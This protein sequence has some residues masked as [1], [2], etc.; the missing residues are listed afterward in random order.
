MQLIYFGLVLSLSSLE[1]CFV[2]CKPAFTKTPSSNGKV[3][4]DKGTNSFA[5]SWDFNTDGE[6][7]TWVDL[8]YKKSGS[9]D[10]LIA[11]KIGKQLQVPRTTNYF[12]RVTTTT[13]KATFVIWYIAESDER[14][15]ECKVYFSSVS[16]PWIMSAVKLIVVVKPKITLYTT[17]ALLMTEGDTRTLLCVASGNP[18]PSYT[19]YKNNVRVQEGSDN[20]NYT[21]T[22][23]N[24]YQTGM[25]RCEA[26]VT[27]STLGPYRADYNVSVT[28]RYKPQHKVN[29]L[30]RNETFYL[31]RDA[32]F[33]C[34]TEAFPIAIHVG[35]YSCY[36]NNDVGNGKK[37][38]VFLTVHYAPLEITLKPD[39]AVVR[40]NQTLI[41]TCQADA[42]P[43]PRYSW[44][45]NGKTHTK[46]IHNILKL[47]N[48]QVNDAG[49]YTCVA[50]N[51]FGRKNT[52][53]VVNVEYAPA[54]QS[55]TTGTPKNT[56]VQGTPVTVTCSASGYPAP[57]ITIKRNDTVISNVGGFAIP[58]IQVNEEY[59]IYTCEP[60]NTIGTG[61]KKELKITVQVPPT[62]SGKLPDSKNVRKENEA[63][64]YQCGAEGK[65][66]P[67]ITWK[68][69]GK[70][71]IDKPPFNI[72]TT[73]RV[74]S[75]KLRTTQS[76]LTIEQL[77]WRESGT[78]SCLAFNDAG[79]AI[80]S[81]ELEV[82][83]RPVV[84]SMADH[85]KNLTV[86]EGTNATFT[87]KTKGY[88]STQAHMWQFNGSR[89]SGANCSGCHIATF[90]KPYVKKTDA[91]WYSCTGRNILGE[92]PPALAYLT[93]KYRP[94]I[95]SSQELYTVNETRNVSMLCRADGL[96]KPKIVWKKK[97]TS[98]VLEIGEQFHVLNAQDIHNGLY[99][100][101]ASNYLGQH[102]NEVTLNV[103][104]RP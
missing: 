46:A 32:M 12:G 20:S 33:Y 24:R 26:V 8:M 60:R 78:F 43:L 36:G 41:L 35:R 96:P 65:P 87:C 16:N 91:G 85:P 69:K 2:D 52:T 82:E 50:E 19:W 47:T 66:A 76:V 21:I 88:P 68:F 6:T 98:E 44:M 99:C 81:T 56:V 17:Q 79:Q 18:R 23:A 74:S 64:L 38:S 49:N 3:Y 63:I 9:S 72:S 84:Q 54:V 67:N 86:D 22:S 39:P 103:Q 1:W 31:G 37:K 90:T 10:E 53:R 34:R 25:Y 77:T 40:F 57:T 7:V 30:E 48:V 92:G 95:I 102:T 45:F 93:V 58:N 83:Y 55:F 97:G 71:L 70:N 101:T 42:V 100:C 11:R 13:E 29:S 94:T 4:V 14:T 61:A 15:F 75:D 89:I 5:L 27:T 104:T 80:Q 28:V 73:V 51:F 62:I 59:T